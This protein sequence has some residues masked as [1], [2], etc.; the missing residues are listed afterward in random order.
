MATKR[1]DRLLQFNNLNDE[2]QGEDDFH[3]LGDFRFDRDGEVLGPV[4]WEHCQQETFWGWEA[5]DFI[6][7]LEIFALQHSQVNGFYSTHCGERTFELKVDVV[8]QE[9]DNEL[10]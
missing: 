6:V 5:S 2:L 10:N 4:E 8:L 9:I 7:A 1:L 3:F